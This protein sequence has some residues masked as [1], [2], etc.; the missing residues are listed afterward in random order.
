[1]WRAAQDPLDRAESMDIWCPVQLGHDVV[2][3]YDQSI[4]VSCHRGVGLQE[5]ADGLATHLMSSF[6]DGQSGVCLPRADHQLNALLSCSFSH[7]I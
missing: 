4:S 5:E 1:M 6:Q 2:R 7:G 3:R